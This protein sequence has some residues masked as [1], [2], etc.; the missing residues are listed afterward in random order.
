MTG[1]HGGCGGRIG[2]GGGGGANGG[3]GR[4]GGGSNGGV[5]GGFSVAPCIQK[6]HAAGVASCVVAIVDATPACEPSVVGYACPNPE[7]VQNSVAGREKPAQPSKRWHVVWPRCSTSAG[8]P[9][10]PSAF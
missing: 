6:A 3:G 4:G 8:D 5:I 7:Y 2:G 1:G 10:Q 9:E